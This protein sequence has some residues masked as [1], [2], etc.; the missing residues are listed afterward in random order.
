MASGDYIIERALM[1]TN[2]PSRVS[3]RPLRGLLDH[4]RFPLTQ[5]PAGDGH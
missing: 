2:I 5:L 3:I 1:L 4:R